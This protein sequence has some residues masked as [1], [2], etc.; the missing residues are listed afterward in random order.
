[1]PA[2][3]DKDYYIEEFKGASVDDEKELE[4]MIRRASDIIDQVTGY[5]VAKQGIEKLIPFQQ[6]QVKKATAAQ[7][8]FFELEGG[9]EVSTVGDSLNNVNIGNFSYGKG[10]QNNS[11]RSKQ[12]VVSQ[13]VIQYLKPTGLLYSGVSTVGDYYA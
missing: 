11:E 12:N 9:V 8:E 13:A 2:Y 3:I 10:T 5:K 7:V 6:D 4:R 1:M